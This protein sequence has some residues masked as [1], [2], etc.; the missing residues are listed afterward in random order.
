MENDKRN[1]RIKM[2][3]WK[4]HLQHQKQLHAKHKH[5]E[6]YEDQPGDAFYTV[7]D[8]KA[9]QKQQSQPIVRN[10]IMSI[11]VNN[12]HDLKLAQELSMLQLQ[13][14]V[15]PT[16]EGKT[17]IETKT[18]PPE[19]T[20]PICLDKEGEGWSQTPC[21][22]QFLHTACIRQALAIDKRCSLCR[23]EIN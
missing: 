2:E 9:E 18:V 8:H 17:L 21:C 6:L 15:R 20:C 16:S 12:S 1:K 11:V 7:V 22:L 19:S 3:R 4:A 5:V 23:R 14:H 13:P 10:N